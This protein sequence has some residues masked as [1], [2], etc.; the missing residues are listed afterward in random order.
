M[1]I[2]F[3]VPD[4]YPHI[5]GVERHARSVALTLSRQGCRVT[6]FVE[7]RRNSDSLHEVD[8][9]IDIFRFVK[10]NYFIFRKISFKWQFLKNIRRFSQADVIHFHDF[11]TMWLWGL[12]VHVLLRCMGKKI[13]ITFH[14]WEGHVPPQR[15]TVYKRKICELL[16]DG[17][18]CAGHFIEKWYTTH[19]TRITYGGCSPVSLQGVAREF[20]LFI[21][22]LESDT[23]IREYVSA[24]KSVNQLFPDLVLVICGEGS[25][26]EYLRE[27]IESNTIKNIR[28]QGFVQ[29]PE[30]VLEKAHFVF[31]SGYLGMLEAF[32]RRTPVI[33]TYDNEIKKDYLMMMPGSVDKFWITRDA[34]SIVDAIQEIISTD[35]TEKIDN[36]YE[37]AL[38]NTWDTVTAEYLGLYG[39]QG[40]YGCSTSDCSL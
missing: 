8:G 2:I 22:R 24:W 30:E 15:K 19:A 35:I 26:Q 1:N 9:N 3:I 21:G 33:A 10:K 5:G 12:L 16:A 4:Y 25:L 7:K 11:T 40:E 37:F 34:D 31:T 32:S 23:G 38:K 6:V 39:K 36:A 28:F 17:N 14:G 27:Y 13:Y 29:N 18:I 20:A